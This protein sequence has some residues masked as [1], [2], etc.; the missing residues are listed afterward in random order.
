MLSNPPNTF[1]SISIHTLETHSEIEGTLIF[2]KF[3]DL[4]GPFYVSIFFFLTFGK[5]FAFF[6]CAFTYLSV[7]SEILI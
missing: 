3:L 2:H 6:D 7:S 5:F 4:Q 1:L